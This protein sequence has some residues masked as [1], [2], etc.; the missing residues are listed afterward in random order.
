MTTLH[1]ACL[2]LTL[3]C[4]SIAPA[5]AAAPSPSNGNSFAARL[6]TPL[7]SCSASDLI[8]VSFSACTGLLQGNLLQGG[9]GSTVTTSVAAALAQLGMDQPSSAT[10]IEKIGSLGGGSTVDFSTPLAGTT[11]IGLHLGGGSNRFASNISG[12]ATAFYRFEAGNLLD[13][14]GLGPLLTASS[15]VAIF[16]TSS[17]TA[18]P[19]P[20]SYALM[21]AGLLAV[22][23]VARRRA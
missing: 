5:L 12:G 6:Q 14:F 23:F 20:Q 17:V 21:R 15:G 8:G 22:G 18:V 19:E 3:L 11:V 16:Q 4:A 1:R 13:S 9:S 2:S 7:P 10:Y